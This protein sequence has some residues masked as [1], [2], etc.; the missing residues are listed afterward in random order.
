MHSVPARRPYRSTPPP[1]P[2][3]SRTGEPA[4]R[5]TVLAGP[6]VGPVSRPSGRAA[7]CLAGGP[8]RYVISRQASIGGPVP[9]PG[10]ADRLE[11]SIEPVVGRPCLARAA[12]GRPRASGVAPGGEPIGWSTA[13]TE[14]EL[15]WLRPIARADHLAAGGCDGPAGGRAARQAGIGGPVLRPGPVD[16][17]GAAEPMIGRPDSSDKVA[18]HAVAGRACAGGVASFGE[19]V[20]RRGLAVEWEP[21]RTGPIPRPGPRADRLGAGGGPAG[22]SAV[23]QAAIGGLVLETGSA[24]RL[25]VPLEPVVGRPCLAGA[26]ADRLAA[27]RP[28]AGEL[29]GR[30]GRAVERELGWTGPIP[31]P[32]RLADRL[33]SGR[34]VGVGGAAAVGT[35]GRGVAASG[36][37]QGG[38]S[39]WLGGHQEGLA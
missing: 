9:A 17:P 23:R 27:G 25:G 31:R 35:E 20:G 11:K 26:V 13:A 30:W 6:M 16:W 14:W 39:G 2:A 7:D 19:P 15:G 21:G 22:G 38:A 8:P 28:R 18:A 34:G 3:W 4:G 33:A 12:D 24:D 32:G 10:S 36:G 5:P 29:V 37:C 1:V